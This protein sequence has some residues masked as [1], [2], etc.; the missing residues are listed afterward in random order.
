MS[1][2]YKT[3][4]SFT[5]YKL[6]SSAYMSPQSL[7]AA[8]PIFSVHEG[9]VISVSCLHPENAEAPIVSNESGMFIL[10]S[11]AQLTNILSGIL[12]RFF[13]RFTDLRFVQLRKTPAPISVMLSGKDI[14]VK[15]LQS[16]NILPSKVVI[17]SARD[18]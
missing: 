10:L 5:K 6:L 11:A 3:L 7:N 13:G 9:I 1:F 17:P 14:L 15:Y 18:T 12:S 16:S 2:E 8:S 4:S